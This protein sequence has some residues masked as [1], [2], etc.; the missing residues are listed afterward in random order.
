MLGSL[1]G[2]GQRAGI[3]SAAHREGAGRTRG[4][5]DACWSPPQAYLEFFTSRET[6]EALLQVL[7]K[8]ELRVHYHIVDVKVG[9][10]GAEG[11]QRGRVPVPRAP[12]LLP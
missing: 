9:R 3:R 7:T 1:P 6:V 11:T 10:S 12:C 2:A 8:Y 5:R 4:L